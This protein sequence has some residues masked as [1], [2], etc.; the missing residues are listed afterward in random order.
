MR[1]VY[2][3][4]APES[5]AAVVLPACT[6]FATAD[7]AVFDPLAASARALG[8]PGIVACGADILKT[9]SVLV[10]DGDSGKVTT[11]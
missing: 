10:V 3:G 8:K 5:A 9:K 6:A 4:A 11:I 7:G 2:I 1:R